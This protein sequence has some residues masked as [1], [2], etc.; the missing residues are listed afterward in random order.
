MLTTRELDPEHA[1]GHAIGLQVAGCFVA[2]P[3]LGNR[4]NESRESACS[5]W[6]KNIS[7]FAN[8]VKGE[9]AN[10][11]NPERASKV[12]LLICRKIESKNVFGHVQRDE[13]RHEN[14]E[15][16]DWEG[17]YSVDEEGEGAR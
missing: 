9:K 11:L 7:G 2:E 15:E 8:K 5:S 1:P 16:N 14:D 13:R 12:R 17:L 10:W 4:I 3:H 6:K